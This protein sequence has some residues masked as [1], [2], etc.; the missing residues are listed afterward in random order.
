ME[1]RA[2]IL[3]VLGS[4]C[5]S[6][7]ARISSPS[8]CSTSPAPS[9]FPATGIFGGMMMN[10][11]DIVM[12][13]MG[14]LFLDRA[15]AGRRHTRTPH[16]ALRRGSFSAAALDLLRASRRSTKSASPTR[17]R[18][19]YQIYRYCWKPILYYVLTALIIGTD[20]D[21]ARK[22]IVTVLTLGCYTAFSTLATYL[23]EAEAASRSHRAQEQIRRRAHRAG[24]RL[25]RALA[26]RARGRTRTLLAGGLGILGIGLVA[27]GSRGA[28]VAAAVAAVVLMISL[29]RFAG[30]RRL[31]R[32]DRVGG[33]ARRSSCCSWCPTSAAS[34]ARNRSPSSSK[35]ERSTTSPGACSSAGPISGRKSFN[36][37]GSVSVPI[38][39]RLS[40][41]TPT[42]RTTATSRSPST[43]GCRS[44]CSWSS[45]AFVSPS[46]RGVSFSGEERRRRVCCAL[47]VSAAIIA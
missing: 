36:T 30:G 18:I 10:A 14:F 42:R 16:P 12:V 24:H 46:T 8:C 28:I 11:S 22:L 1:S 41:T 25:S 37:R 13:T 23:Q 3:P 21:R 44:R 40:P 32:D 39:T 43:M 6:R 2:W 4:R 5:S 19:A 17:M 9:S 7:R 29:A 20:T 47:G 26:R 38:A 34:Q 31:I 15:L 35:A 45:S 27:A 33:G